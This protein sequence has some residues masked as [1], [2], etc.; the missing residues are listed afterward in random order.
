MDLRELVLALLAG[1]LLTARQWVADA[2]RTDLCWEEVEFP[3]NLTA[4]ELAVAAAVVELLASR[5][6]RPAPSW[7]NTVGAVRELLV[8][9]PGLDRMPRSF[10]HAK[11]NGPEPLRRRNMVALPDFL[12]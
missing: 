7:T 11:G 9:D 6:G 12:L 2:R 8:L 5:A 4:I 1:D 3:S 10:E